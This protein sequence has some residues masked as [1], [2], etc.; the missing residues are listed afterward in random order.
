MRLTRVI[1]KLEPGGTQ[2]GVLR[3]VAPLRRLGIETRVLAGH[4]TREGRRLFAAAGGVPEG[5]SRGDARIQYEPRPAFADW[6]A[7]RLA[8]SDVVH[9]HMFGAWW[10]AAHAIG[11]ATPLA[12]RAHKRVRR[13]GEPRLAEMRSALACVDLLFAHGP[14]ARALFGEL[15]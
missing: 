12:A 9:A 15:G 14:S 3:I 13:Q 7:P 6:L 4:A 5:W 1:G 10:A 8:G 2:L 11:T